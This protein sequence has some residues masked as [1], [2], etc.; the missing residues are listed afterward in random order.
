MPYNN[1]PKYNNYNRPSGGSYSPK[2]PVKSF[3]DLEIYQQALAASVAAAGIT[4]IKDKK[5]KER[6]KEEAENL[7]IHNLLPCA[8]GLPHLIAEAHSFRFGAGTD[9]LVLLEKTMVNCNKLVVYLEQVRDICQTSKEHD[10]FQELIKK[11]LYIRRKTLNL[12]R[13]WK[14]YIEHPDVPLPKLPLR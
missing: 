7:I 11:Y 12:Q 3:M 8:L 6:I 5:K 2:K 14:K 4:L 9:C 1:Y 13:V 10:F